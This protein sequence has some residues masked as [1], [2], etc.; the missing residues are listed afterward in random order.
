MNL[1]RTGKPRRCELTHSNKRRSDYANP[2]F[3]LLE[4]RVLVMLKV[5]N[6]S[7]LMA[8]ST[9]RA[10]LPHGGQWPILECA[11]CH[12]SPKPTLFVSTSS[13][14]CGKITTSQWSLRSGRRC[15]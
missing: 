7:P 12:P 14:S 6:E 10:M 5:M 8:E 2:E 4:T 1:E 15:N 11:R 13:G 3:P 9:H